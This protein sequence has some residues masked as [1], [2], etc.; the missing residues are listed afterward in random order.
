M[1]NFMGTFSPPEKSKMDSVFGAFVE[2]ENMVP[3]ENVK[4]L[5]KLIEIWKLLVVTKASGCHKSF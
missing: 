3:I 2:S 5:N 1:E 4:C